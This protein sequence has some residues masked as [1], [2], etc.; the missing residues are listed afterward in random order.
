M[1]LSVELE[2]DAGRGTEKAPDHGLVDA[3][4]AGKN[5]GAPKRKIKRKLLAQQH[6]KA[7]AEG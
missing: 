2:A 1:T 3:G 5:A 7:E 6:A 4:R